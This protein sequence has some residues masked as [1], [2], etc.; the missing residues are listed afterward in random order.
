[1]TFAS[2]YPGCISDSQLF[3]NHYNLFRFIFPKFQKY[4]TRGHVSQ[5]VRTNTNTRATPAYPEP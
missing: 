1:M 5:E 3:R 4:V 2:L